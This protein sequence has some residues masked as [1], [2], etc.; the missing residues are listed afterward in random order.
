MFGRMA[1][2]GLTVM[3]AM[4]LAL[5]ILVILGVYAPLWLHWV[6]NGADLIER[7]VT[8]TGLPSKYN[9][10]V[11]IFAASEAIVILI[12]TI[13]ARIILAVV[14]APVSPRTSGIGRLLASIGS[15][16]ASLFFAFVLGILMLVTLGIIA[17]DILDGMLS[18]AGWVEARLEHTGLPFR[19][20]N[21]L[22][23]LIADDQILLLFFTIVA[24]MLIALVA[25]SLSAA[26]G[27][28]RSDY[29]VPAR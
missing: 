11:G 20:N 8:S 12:F 26:M 16:T 4:V 25:T 29:L 10:W 9:V 21:I 22:R 18:A 7:A 3:V 2:T 1:M 28:N 24:R 13:I 17:P 6:Q 15:M 5:A 23:L 27:G 14:L 19:W